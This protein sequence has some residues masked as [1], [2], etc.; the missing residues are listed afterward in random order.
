[1]ETIPFVDRKA[2]DYRLAGPGIRTGRK[3]RNDV[4][5]DTAALC[6]ALGAQARSQPMCTPPTIETR[7]S[8]S[9]T[10]H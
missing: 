2:G 9:I 3:S 5:V 7:H 1:M 4:G 8:S 6:A 10:T